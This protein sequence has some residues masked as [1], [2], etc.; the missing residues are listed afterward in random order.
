MIEES[1]ISL[2]MFQGFLASFDAYVGYCQEHPE[3][4]NALD[5]MIHEM[6]RVLNNGKD[7][8][9]PQLSEVLLPIAT[10]YFMLLAVKNKD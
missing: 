3:D 9:D 8:C 10:P 1:E 7:D 4:S 5:D 2:E 6:K